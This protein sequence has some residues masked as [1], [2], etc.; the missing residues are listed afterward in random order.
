MPDFMEELEKP[1]LLWQCYILHKS[2]FWFHFKTGKWLINK[3]TL[4]CLCIGYLQS[5]E[6]LM[7]ELISY[8]LL[9]QQHLSI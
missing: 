2:A 9:Q 3:Q 7:A 1:Q 6:L 4:S 5:T 8:L